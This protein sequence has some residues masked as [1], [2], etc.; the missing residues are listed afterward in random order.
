MSQPLYSKVETYVKQLIED[1]GL[2]AGNLLPTELELIER[3]SVSRS[4]LR[5]ALNNLQSQGLISKQQG[6]GTFVAEPFYEENLSSLTGFSEDIRKKGQSTSAIVLT[7]QL[8]IPTEELANS[9]H[10]TVHD[11]VFCLERIRFVEKVPVQLTISY[12]PEK[13]LKHLDLTSVDFTNESLYAT[14]ERAG[15]QITIGTETLEATLSTRR[16]EAL[17]GIPENSPILVNRRKVF[18]EKNELIEMLM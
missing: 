8:I 10:I 4:T 1:N 14:L 2:K 9:L 3:L 7:N 18:N 15:I 11:R 17:L 6:R 13:Y 16:D 5:Y 12:L